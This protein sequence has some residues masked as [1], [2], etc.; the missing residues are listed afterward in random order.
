MLV[1]LTSDHLLTILMTESDPLVRELYQ[2]ELGREYR[3]LACAD[4]HEALG[5]LTA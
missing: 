2:R 1:M 5:I 4:E 3:V